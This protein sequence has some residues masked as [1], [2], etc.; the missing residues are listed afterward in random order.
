MF[1]L[2][3]AYR[4]YQSSTSDDG[5]F[6]FVTAAVVLDKYLPE[7]VVHMAVSRYPE[8]LGVKNRQTG[9]IP[10]LEAA[11]TPMVSRNRADEIIALLLQVYPQGIQTIDLSGKSALQL[12]IESGKPWLAGVQRLFQAHPH[13]ISWRDT[14]GT[15]PVLAAASAAAPNQT[16]AEVENDVNVHDATNPVGLLSPKCEEIIRH[17]RLQV[18][19][20]TVGEGKITD[21]EQLSTILD[22]LRLDPSM[23]LN[24][25]SLPHVQ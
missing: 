7:D 3:E 6:S 11:A 4:Y 22:L 13:A 16:L 23:I 18:F 5:S 20:P 24:H 19:K 25:H 14:S 9:R 15:F 21:E 17:R 10:L 1:L 12:A 2:Q 8:Q